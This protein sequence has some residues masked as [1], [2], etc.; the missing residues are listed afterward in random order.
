MPALLQI[1]VFLMYSLLGNQLTVTKAFTTVAL[2]NLLN[3]P[4]HQIPGAV[5]SVLRA[6][7]SI[8]RVSAF[9]QKDEFVP[10][11]S[12]DFSTVVVDEEYLTAEGKRAT[13]VAIQFRG[14][15]AG[16]ILDS[17]TEEPSKKQDKA[18]GD[19]SKET[20]HRDVDCG[21]IELTAPENQT[22]Q[23]APT[24]PPIN[25]SVH[26]LI[27][28]SF[29]IFKGELV[30]I[31]GTV[32]SGKSSLLYSLMNELTV[33]SGSIFMS[34]GCSIAYHSQQPWILNRTIKENITL[35]GAYD[36]ERFEMA[37]KGACLGN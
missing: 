13:D 14:V 33:S 18:E 34:S 2:L 16:W 5:T 3:A 17:D 6:K 8:D 32:S 35:G 7:V 20:S 27:D 19:R 10:C 29:T 9:L 37:V 11:V 21:D 12:S 4:M 31:V 30:A 28:A 24:D 1:G 36:E 25:R 15:N 26:T 22:P 23:D